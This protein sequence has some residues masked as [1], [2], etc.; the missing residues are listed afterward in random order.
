[1]RILQLID[2]LELGGAERMA[3]NYANAL[4]SRLPF[5]GLVCSRREG[6]LK[7]QLLPAVE[8]SFL[9]KKS[10]F[11]LQAVLRLWSY[12]RNN[13]VTHIQAQSTSFF[14]AFLLKMLL[15]KT[16]L[17]WH[18]H[19][20]LSEFLNSRKAGVLKI[21][22]YSFSGVISV[23]TILKE[24]AE[25]NLHCKQTTYLANFAIP[26]HPIQRL[27]NLKGES[28][29]RILCLA[30]LRSQKNH[31]LIIDMALLLEEVDPEWTFHLVGT[32]FE[33]AYS[34]SLRERIR[35]ED[36]GKQVFLYGA[37]TDIANII[38]QADI[39]LL[40][41]SSEGLP[42]ALIEYGFYSKPVL[43]SAVGE[44][45]SLIMNNK[46]G[47]LAPSGD[48]KAF[49]EGLLSLIA[50]PEKRHRFGE[51]LHETVLKDYSEAPVLAKYLSFVKS[52]PA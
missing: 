9:D 29:K 43:A 28:G 27:T 16:K 14:T 48:V 21:A 49:Y 26:E 34:S 51:A 12:C 1:M 45:P 6:A 44:I 17:I 42:V 50:D 24:W 46:N 15:P 37:K 5:S 19:Y 30:N 25:V 38:E 3:V 39:A 2:S 36:V 35:Y 47:L 41:S 40:T 33:D 23:N 20:G 22:S 8:Y 11:D 18:D 4:S 31:D 10:A 32:D 13:K 7:E 52:L